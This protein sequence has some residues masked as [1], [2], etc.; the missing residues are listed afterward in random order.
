MKLRENIK[1]DVCG[2]RTT[3]EISKEVFFVCAKCIRTAGQ[4]YKEASDLW[5]K[6]HAK[7]FREAKK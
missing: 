1:C 4:E 3:R 5:E 7:E 2:K 6:E